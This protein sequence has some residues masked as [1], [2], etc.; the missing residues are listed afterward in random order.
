MPDT[1]SFIE[2]KVFN[3]FALFVRRQN[4]FAQMAMNDSVKFNSRYLTGS[5]V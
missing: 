2:K 5:K 3:C 4:T 1:I